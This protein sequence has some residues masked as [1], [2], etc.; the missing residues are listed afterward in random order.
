[1]YIQATNMIDLIDSLVNDQ[2]V[3]LDEDAG[4]VEAAR[5]LVEAYKNGGVDALD[6]VLDRW[7]SEDDADALSCV[8]AASPD[9][10]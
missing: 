9:Q 4:T 8:D 3:D 10:G 6:A 5:E 1:M 2:D 7:E